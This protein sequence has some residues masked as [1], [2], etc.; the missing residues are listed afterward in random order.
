MSTSKFNVHSK[1]LDQF[2]ASKE[3][4]V[5]YVGHAS[6]LVRLNGR[7]FLFDPV[8]ERPPYLESWIFYPSQVLD[9]R[10]L[11]VD[12][13]V[14]SHCHQDHFDTDFL[15][16]LNPKTKIY[17]VGGRPEFLAMFKA[18]GI[19]VNEIPP[20]KKYGLGDGVE[21]YGV[22][23]EYNTIDSSTIIK[24]SNL[25]VYHGN[26]NYVTKKTLVPMREAMG[27]VDV[28]C[29]PFSFIHWYP[30]LLE[31]LDEA[32]KASEAKRLIEKYLDLGIQQAQ[33]L[34]AGL[35]IPFGA[36]LVYHDD[37]NS[38]MNKSVL[39]PIDFVEYTYSKLSRDEANR[40]K[41]MFAGDMILKSPGKNMEVFCKPRTKAEFIDQLQIYLQDKKNQSKLNTQVSVDTSL[42]KDMRWL[43]NKLKSKNME[44]VDHDIRITTLGLAP[45]S[46]PIK[47][48]VNLSDY[49]V[50]SVANWTPG[51]K[52]HCFKVEPIAL[53]PW[54]R[55]E[56]SFEEV[57]GTRRFRV[58]RAPNE[59]NLKVI[60]ILNNA[61]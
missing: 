8:F 51:R 10:L 59:Y 57:I 28:G 12:A 53:N 41:P 1:E 43:E 9:T 17:I 32:W 25:S 26:D 44:T 7:K 60:E 46:N 22:L 23:H 61:L 36:N 37:A 11:D 42:L 13:V 16:H 2:L 55:N 14:V 20:G 18:A 39:S 3:D 48:E 52:Y 4:G 27:A 30:F 38:V 45:D 6:I 34:G 21:I 29:V 33:S 47:I 58:E 15:K 49:S 50:K 56:I 31:G 5:F 40:Y 35:I 24:N 54:L 19:E